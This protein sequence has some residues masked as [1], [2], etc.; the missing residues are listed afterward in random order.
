MILINRCFEIFTHESA[1]TGEAAESG[2]LAENE[3]VSFRELVALLRDGEP[4]SSP[5]TG[6]P[7][8]W[9]NHDQGE[10]REYYEDGIRETQSV[11]YSRDNPARRER[12]WRLV[13]VAAGLT[14]RG[15][16]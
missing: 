2:M 11:H 8:E 10:T 3:S 4:S 13:F 6:S 7:H 16:P 14:R 1:E 12:Y 9:V 15:A 5:V